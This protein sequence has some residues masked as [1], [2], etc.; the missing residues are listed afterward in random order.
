M[1][2]LHEEGRTLVFTTH[3]P[4]DVHRLATRVVW[5]HEGRLE[6]DRAGA[7]ELR[8]YERMLEQDR[9]GDDHESLLARDDRDDRRPDDGG[10]LRAGANA[11]AGAA[12]PR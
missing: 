10:L 2:A 11:R 5:L 1:R 6:S 3:V 7:F 12:R 8:R 9:W 4:S